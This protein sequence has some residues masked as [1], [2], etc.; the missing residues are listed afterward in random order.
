MDASASFSRIY[1]QTI[2]GDSGSINVIKGSDGNLNFTSTTTHYT[3]PLNTLALVYLSYG[4]TS[5]TNRSIN[6][7]NSNLTRL[8]HSSSVDDGAADGVLANVL[9]IKE[10]FIIR[11]G[12]S[13]RTVGTI[14]GIGGAADFNYKVYWVI[15]EFVT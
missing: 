11:P 3:A 10:S 7:G 12:D 5:H 14:S 15:I 8:N 13:L 4:I 9:R 2:I 1:K 6:V